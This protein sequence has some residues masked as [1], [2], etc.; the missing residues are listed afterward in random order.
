LPQRF[1]LRSTAIWN[2]D[3]EHGAYYIPI[4]LGAGKIWN[5]PDGTT[6]NL[7]AERQYTVGHY[8]SAPQRHLYR[9][10]FAVSAQA[11]IH[12]PQSCG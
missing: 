3:L 5:E 2:L 1:Y 4:G 11:L 10:Q 6:I 7:F 9:T 8:Q 12:T